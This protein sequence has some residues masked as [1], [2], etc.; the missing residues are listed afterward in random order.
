MASIKG[1]DTKVEL[2]LRKALYRFG[3]RYRVNSSK[4]FGK[5]D[6]SIRKYKIAIFID[7]DWWHGR[8]YEKESHKYTEFWQ[9]KISK[10]MKRDEQVNSKLKEQGWE[11]FR[12]W[13]KD[14]EKNPSKFVDLVYNIVE[15]LKR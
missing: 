10:N 8:N 9:E 4:V 1:R 3:I 2:M 12:F 7:G 14:I 11:V 15:Q 6:I 5:P 13:Q